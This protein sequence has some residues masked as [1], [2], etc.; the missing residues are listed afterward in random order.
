M[1]YLELLIKKKE[2][3][4]PEVDNAVF[5]SQC[6]CYRAARDDESTHLCKKSIKKN[7]VEVL[8]VLEF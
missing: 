3:W 5:F 6:E 1:S 8:Q 7:I 4:L 2:L